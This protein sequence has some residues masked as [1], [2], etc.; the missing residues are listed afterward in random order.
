MHYPMVLSAAVKF[1]HGD[2][3][4]DNPRSRVTINPRLYSRNGKE[5]DEGITTP[6]KDRTNADVWSRQRDFCCFDVYLNLTDFI[7]Y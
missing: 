7:S 2:Q 4:D 3:H 1:Y 5:S 6:F